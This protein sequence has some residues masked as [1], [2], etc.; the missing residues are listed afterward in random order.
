MFTKKQPLKCFEIT[1]K[2]INLMSLINLFIDLLVKIDCQF[3]LVYASNF[4]LNFESQTN[5]TTI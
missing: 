5:V 2:K 4:L 1:K 3:A